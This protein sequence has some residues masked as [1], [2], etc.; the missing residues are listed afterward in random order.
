M[1]IFWHAYFSDEPV[2]SID[3][4]E[5]IF[6]GG[7]I[8]NHVDINPLEW[9]VNLQKNKAD[10]KEPID[11]RQRKFSHSRQLVMRC[12]SKEDEGNYQAFLSRESNG[13]NYK[14]FSKGIILFMKK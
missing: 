14:I 9:S 6:C 13:K 7:T 10:A 1:N 11:I 5:D 12:V 8:P 3:N 2:I 4:T